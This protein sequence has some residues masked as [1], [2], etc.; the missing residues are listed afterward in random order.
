ME[1]AFIALVAFFAAGY[2][3]LRRAGQ[4]PVKDA[5]EYL[6]KGALIIDVRSPAEFKARH[7][8]N[9]INLP[10]D[11]IETTLPTRVKDRTQPILLHCQA[12]TRSTVAKRKL[13]ALGYINAYNLGSYTRAERIIKSA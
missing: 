6:H 5:H 10:V 7:L 1:W 3:F 8:P 9:A 2:I 4:V 13:N 11:Q 12:G